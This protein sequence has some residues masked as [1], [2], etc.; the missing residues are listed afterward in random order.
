MRFA[1]KI[2]FLALIVFLAG[3]ATAPQRDTQSKGGYKVG[4]PYSI[5]GKT[6]TPAV[7]YAYNETGI[8][9]WYGPGFH[10]KKTANGE[11][12]YRNELTAA[13]KTLPMPS[14]V[15]VTNLENGKSLVMRINDRGPFAHGRLIDVSER[16]ADLLGFKSAGT[17]RVRVQV[18]EQE[19]RRI[20]EV[21]KSGQSTRG[22]ELA[23]NG[24]RSRVDGALLKQ[25]SHK[26]DETRNP[27]SLAT[28]RH[29]DIPGHIRNGHFYPDAVMSTMPVKKTN[30]FVQVGSFSSLENARDLKDK[31]AQSG[32][33]LIHEAMIAGHKFY[34]VRV[35]ARDISD[36][37]VIL[38]G[39]AQKGHKNA[40]IVVE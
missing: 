35:P 36:A 22:A 30:L 34:R 40:M 5:K 31:L 6:Y 11:I 25:V 3:C 8:A 2:V 24:G 13:H 33:P 10:G 28:E 9:S 20:A 1:Q 19:S 14:I 21:A 39:L 4:N 7:D 32:N 12:F 18:L 26:S 16:G 37:D 27:V 38:K 15:R 17:A 29:G 23:L